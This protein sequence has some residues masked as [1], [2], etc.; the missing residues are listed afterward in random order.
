MDIPYT[1]ENAFGVCDDGN[2][3]I[4][5]CNSDCVNV[6]RVGILRCSACMIPCYCSKQCQKK[7]LA[8]AQARV[9]SFQSGNAT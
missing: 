2:R 3:R 5:C 7:L 8:D 6:L 4:V 9:L 1:T